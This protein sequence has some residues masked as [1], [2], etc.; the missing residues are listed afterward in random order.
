MPKGLKLHSD[1]CS[2]SPNL[3]GLDVLLGNL[4][5]KSKNKDVVL[6]CMYELSTLSL[7]PE[8][9]AKVQEQEG[10]DVVLEAIAAFPKD[11]E[12]KASAREVCGFLGT[13]LP[14]SRP[15]VVGGRSCLR[16]W[17]GGFLH[18]DYHCKA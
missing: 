9:K 6:T 12:V 14:R 18:F 16:R 7:V 17:N 8:V 4:G 13:R 1:E 2:L 3:Q 11:N 15:L 5:A 10:M